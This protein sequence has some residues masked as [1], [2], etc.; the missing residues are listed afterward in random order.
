M[1]LFDFFKRRKQE[2]KQQETPQYSSEK[3]K[4]GM[5]VIDENADDFGYSALNPIP[6]RDLYD[7]INYFE[8]LHFN[9]TEKKVIHKYIG[10][11]EVEGFDRPVNKY[12]ISNEEGKQICHFYVAIFHNYTSW[13][14]PKGFSRFKPIKMVTQQNLD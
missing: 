6:I 9:S 12:L 11:E 8:F 4:D 7:F 13:Y 10:Q 5:P 14:T 3:K 2:N 1:G